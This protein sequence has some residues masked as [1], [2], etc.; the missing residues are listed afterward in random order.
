MAKDY[1]IGS[2]ESVHGDDVYEE[3]NLGIFVRGYIK[4]PR[5]GKYGFWISN[6]ELA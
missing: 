1:I 2:W 4:A 6:D 3:D 5:T